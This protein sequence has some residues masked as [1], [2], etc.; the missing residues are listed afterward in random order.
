[1]DHP[2]IIR[3]KSVY[4]DGNKLYLVTELCAGGELFHRLEKSWYTMPIS[5][6]CKLNIPEE[7]VLGHMTRIVAAV[8][9]CHANGIVHGDLKPENFVFG[10]TGHNSC[11]LKLIDFGLSTRYTQGFTSP[12]ATKIITGSLPYMAPE[13]LEGQCIPAS[14]MW[15]LGVIAY[16]LLSG[17][18][19][20]DADDDEGIKRRINNAEVRF[21]KAWWEGSTEECQDFIKSLLRADP[22]QRLTGE[23][24]MSH[25][26][27]GVELA[28][29]EPP[30]PKEKGD[31]VQLL[32]RRL[33]A[34]KRFGPLKKM[35][36]LCVALHLD[37]EGVAELRRLFSKIDRNHDGMIQTEEL[38]EVLQAPEEECNILFQELD[39]TGSGFVSYSEF[40]A[41]MMERSCF[42]DASLMHEAWM[43][44]D[45]NDTGS[46][47]TADLE[48]L[49]GTF[50]GKDKI[51]DMIKEAD[52]DAD[53]FVTKEE[54]MHVML[55]TTPD[56]GRAEDLM[57]EMGAGLQFDLK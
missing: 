54:W 23:A 14:D 42:L 8:S 22:E 56:F 30:T 45:Q 9:Y 28:Y 12:R 13:M 37:H 10:K 31:T 29:D 38:Q 20:F 55:G 16:V 4:E 2:N 39:Q 52:F 3:I 47:C 50:I 33:Q 19:P 53:G 44:L 1:M 21:P 34:Y 40:M 36:L 49:L 11:D 18:N 25:P 6:N 27:F 43:L 26:W 5:K 24:A 7:E 32:Q 51:E 35:S 17:K 41:A 15:S 57:E 48:R 46:I